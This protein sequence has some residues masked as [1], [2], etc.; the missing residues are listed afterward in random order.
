MGQIWKCNGD[1]KR[2]MPRWLWEKDLSILSNE[3][4]MAKVLL[5]WKKAENRK[6]I[7]LPLVQNLEGAVLGAD[8]I[9]REN[10]WTTG[11]YPFS[12][13]EE[14]K[15]E[16]FTLMQDKRIKTII[17]VTKKLKEKPLILEAEAPFSILAALIDP[18]KLYLAMQME[19]EKLEKILKKIVLE[20]AEY[21]KAVIQAGCRIISLAEPTATMDMVGEKCFKECSG[22]ATFMFL[23]EIEKFLSN[24]VVHLCGKGKTDESLKGTTGYVQYE[25]IQDELPDLFAMA[26]VVISR[27]GANAICEIRELHKPNLLIPLSAKASRGD[28]ILNARSFERQ[29]FSMVLEE[30]EITETKLLDTIHQLYT[31]RQKYTEAMA[32]NGRVD[33]IS[34]ITEL[35]EECARS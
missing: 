27:A 22:M 2:T 16:Q 32:G 5:A 14:I 23:K 17:E 21:I 7:I 3:E 19:P 30:E 33:S 13:L 6:E 34:K 31:D 1:D 24:S 4:E 28:Q 11:D 15:P 25:Y 8:V 9:K 12:R 35:I 26:D 20:E 29:G 10:Y 18:M